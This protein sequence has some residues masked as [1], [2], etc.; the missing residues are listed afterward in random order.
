LTLLSGG[1]PLIKTPSARMKT[2]NVHYF[3]L[4]DAGDVLLFSFISML[5]GLPDI[6]AK[7]PRNRVVYKPPDP[8]YIRFGLQS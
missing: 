7:G 5:F 1:R 6:R 8:E 4:A 3:S 2:P